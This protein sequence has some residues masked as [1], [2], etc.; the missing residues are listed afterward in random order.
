MSL[1]V[2][3]SRTASNPPRHGSGAY[4]RV[5]ATIRYPPACRPRQ[6][7]DRTSCNAA[8][9]PPISRSTSLWYFRRHAQSGSWL[10][11]EERESTE[12]CI[13]DLV[14]AVL[15][16]DLLT[17]AECNEMARSHGFLLICC[18]CEEPEEPISGIFILEGADDQ[19][20]AFCGECIR[21]IS[22]EHCA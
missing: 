2:W 19:L 22:V 7:T 13:T 14:S 17:I 15:I 12:N 11:I 9:G 8:S 3:L 4:T 1:R 20:W 5:A 18:A 10:G 21:Q 16:D 6:Q